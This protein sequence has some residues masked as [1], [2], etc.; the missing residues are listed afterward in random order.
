MAKILD[1]NNIVEILKQDE[2]IPAREEL[3]RLAENTVDLLATVVANHYDIYKGQTR[4]EGIEFGG[5][6]VSFFPSEKGQACPKLVDEGDES[7]DWEPRGASGAYANRK[8][9]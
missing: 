5:V 3:M 8:P 1:L 4:S 6:C 9:R 7:G 2:N